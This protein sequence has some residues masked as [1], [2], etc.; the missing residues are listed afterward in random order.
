MLPTTIHIIRTTTTKE[1]EPNYNVT[2][3]QTDSIWF[4]KNKIQD[5]DS[6]SNNSTLD[7]PY[8]S[9]PTEC[10][11][12]ESNNNII[13]FES[14]HGKNNEK[15]A[16]FLINY[17]RENIPNSD[18][19]LSL[20]KNGYSLNGEVSKNIK[21]YRDEAK[22]LSGEKYYTFLADGALK[23]KCGNC[24]EMS[25]ASA[26]LLKKLGYKDKISVMTYGINHVFLIIGNKTAIDPWAE[27]FCNVKDIK[28]VLKGFG[29]KIDHEKGISY[30][31][32]LNL[33]QMQQD[34]EE[35]DMIDVL[36]DI[37]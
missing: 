23:T 29:G 19:R 32:L 18:T 16:E 31:K 7:S 30:G 24:L 28:Q 10:F 35:D 27:T 37:Q 2:N 33:E 34:F 12:T 21:K 8:L 22:L 15:I 5:N 25:V 3:K 6:S 36:I 17:T 20:Q 4:P 1:K 9:K 14:I 11:S 13:Q 26:I